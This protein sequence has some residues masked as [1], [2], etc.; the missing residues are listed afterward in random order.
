MAEDERRRQMIK[1]LA[2]IERRVREENARPRKRYVSVSTQAASYAFYYDTL[3]QSIEAKGTEN[4]PSAAG[5]K[6]YGELTMIIPINHDGQVLATEVVLSSGN[7]TLDRR[8]QA[9]VRSAAPFGRF[10][11][12]MRREFDQYVV[13]ASL[14]FTH[15]AALELRLQSP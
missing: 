9:I 3:R 7:L 5:N 15:D 10:N 8:A 14:K 4:F 2:E 12:A 1:L 13:V 6:L 11:A